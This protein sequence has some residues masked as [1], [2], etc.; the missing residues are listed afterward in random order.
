MSGGKANAV[1]GTIADGRSLRRGEADRHGLNQFQKDGLFVFKLAAPKSP[2]VVHK[3]QLMPPSATESACKDE[4]WSYT[5]LASGPANRLALTAEYIVNTLRDGLRKGY[6]QC[7]FEIPPS[8]RHSRIIFKG[9]ALTN[10]LQISRTFR[11]LDG[12]DMTIRELI[13]FR[14]TL[15]KNLPPKPANVLKDF[16]AQ[17][18]GFMT[19]HECAAGTRMKDTLGACQILWS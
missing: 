13:N 17:H 11:K 8:D 15:A 1:R 12:H 19:L 6:T 16:V 4:S 5:V 7:D 9:S 10:R 2:V 14:V 18:S 3:N